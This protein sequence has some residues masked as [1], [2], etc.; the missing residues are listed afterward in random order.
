M[1]DW[2]KMTEKV[3]QLPMTDKKG[4]IS[5]AISYLLLRSVSWTRWEGYFF[6]SLSELCRTWKGRGPGGTDRLYRDLG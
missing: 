5:S 2:E 4:R 3:A 6:P 1:A